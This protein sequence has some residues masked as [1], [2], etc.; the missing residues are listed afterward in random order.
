MTFLEKSKQEHR[1]INEDHMIRDLCPSD[2]GYEA[3]VKCKA[4]IGADAK[5]R[6]Y[7]CRRCG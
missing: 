3:K 5:D 4:I 1:I 6:A 7:I 2:L